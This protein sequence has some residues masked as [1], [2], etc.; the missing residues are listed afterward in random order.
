MIAAESTRGV[1]RE[2]PRAFTGFDLRTT[3]T[4][5]DAVAARL[6]RL[7]AERQASFTAIVNEALRHGLAILTA[8][9]AAAPYRT[10]ARH[11]GPFEGADPTKLGQLDDQLDDLGRM[12]SADPATP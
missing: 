5:D 6:K 10:K 11:L 8:P 3:L 4:L 1:S 2:S 12:G 7:A 9:P